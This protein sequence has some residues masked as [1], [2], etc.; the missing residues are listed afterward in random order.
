M[1]W[2][3]AGL[4]CAMAYAA[5]GA[6]QVNVGDLICTLAETGERGETPPSQT[7]PMECTFRPN[8]TGPEESYSGEI[9]NVGSQT[10][11][12]GTRVLLWA[13]MGPADRKLRPGQ[14]GQT[15]S[16]QLAA[17]KADDTQP[18]GVLIGDEDGA[19]AL[20]FMPENSMVTAPGNLTVVVLKIKVAP[21]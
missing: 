5:P 9:Q 19:Y 10:A 15:F 21:A 3:I 12:N 17:S 4:L 20:R 16:G 14:L 2:P 7:L 6:M 11:L 8:G 1:K 18:S 13:V